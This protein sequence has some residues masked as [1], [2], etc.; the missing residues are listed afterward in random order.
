MPRSSA[1]RNAPH[2]PTVA[3]WIETVNETE[4][5]KIVTGKNHQQGNLITLQL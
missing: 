2:A 4:E 1:L 3:W 5:G